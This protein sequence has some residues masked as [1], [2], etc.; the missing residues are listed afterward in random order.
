MGGTVRQKISEIIYNVPML[1]TYEKISLFWCV[2]PARKGGSGHR[3]KT[4]NI[5][6]ITLSI[7]SS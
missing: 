2:V 1:E 3:I 4:I 6:F 5:L 7:T